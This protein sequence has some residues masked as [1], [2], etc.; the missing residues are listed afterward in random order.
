MAPKLT[1]GRCG[2]PH[3]DGSVLV[4]QRPLG[5]HHGCYTRRPI[6]DL[7]CIANT[8]LPEVSLILA[9]SACTSSTTPSGIGI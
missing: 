9:Q 3:F 5:F 1:V 4:R 7:H 2:P 8:G 6:A